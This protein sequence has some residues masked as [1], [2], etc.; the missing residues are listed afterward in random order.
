MAIIFF[1]LRN[2]TVLQWHFGE[3]FNNRNILKTRNGRSP[4]VKIPW[5]MVASCP[6]NQEKC[7]ILKKIFFSVLL[8]IYSNSPKILSVGQIIDGAF[9]DN[10]WGLSCIAPRKR[11]KSQSSNKYSHL[12]VHY[13]LLLTNF[14]LRWR[15][16][17]MKNYNWSC[18]LP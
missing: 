14:R 3:V 17:D 18:Q 5:D 10:R 12:Y 16:W 7:K 9:H 13:Y 6:K 11:S 4:V 1:R 2:S 15:Q 8:K